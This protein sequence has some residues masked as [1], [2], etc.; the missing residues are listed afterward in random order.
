MSNQKSI[1]QQKI[2]SHWV[3]SKLGM[4]IFLYPLSRL[5]QSIAYLRRQ[6]YQKKIFKQIKLP[7]PV[8]IVG[9]I[10]VGG[11]GKTPLVVALVESLKQRGIQVGVVS[12][13][14]GREATGILMVDKNGSAADYGDEPLM[15]HRKT[16]VPVAVGANRISAAR[17]L[18]ANHPIDIILA[19]DGLQ[20]YQLQ[21]DLEIVA[22]PANDMNKKLDSLPNGPLRE[23]L[24]RLNSIDALVVT[25]M[26]ETLAHAVLVKQFNLNHDVLIAQSHLEEGLFYQLTNTSLQVTADFFQEKKIA[27]MAGIGSPQKFFR[28]LSRLGVDCEKKI[29]F[30]DHYEYKREDMP[31]DMDIIIV[32]EKDAVKMTNFKLDNVWVLPVNATIEP[33]LAQFII[34]KLSLH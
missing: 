20:H 15:I 32:T 5:F 33:D 16:G 4:S 13:G 27:A 2:E 7:V 8:V 12:R 14:Y 26:A 22:F 6:A 23:P 21:R 10:H 30:P 9:N 17:L 11:V 1:L 29:S 28:T 3:Q 25:G 19:D 31:D 34:S 18:L 24:A